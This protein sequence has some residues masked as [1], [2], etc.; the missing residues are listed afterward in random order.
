[1][2]QQPAEI[3]VQNPVNL[4]KD[5]Q[6]GGVRPRFNFTPSSLMTPSSELISVP[7]GTDQLINEPTPS[8]KSPSIVEIRRI[9][10][11]ASTASVDLSKRIDQVKGLVADAG[12][13]LGIDPALSM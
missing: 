10:H 8:V 2:S 12:E 13:K 5:D 6:E 1:D 7:S 11:H 3:K 9:T 4:P